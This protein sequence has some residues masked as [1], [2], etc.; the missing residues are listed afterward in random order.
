MK[1][2]FLPHFEGAILG[3]TFAVLRRTNTQHHICTA[4][5]DK[6]GGDELLS[7]IET[8]MSK[9]GT[10]FVE[11]KL[12]IDTWRLLSC[13]ANLRQVSTLQRW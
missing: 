12:H 7:Q 13:K 6:N 3:V 9:S 2:E 1:I 4:S 8:M 11:R 5:P 10:A